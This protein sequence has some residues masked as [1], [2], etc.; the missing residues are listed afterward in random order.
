M[1]GRSET[2]NPREEIMRRIPT[3]ILA[4]VLGLAIG[5]C[6]NGGS[7]SGV[8]TAPGEDTVSTMDAVPGEDTHPGTDTIPGTDT[9]PAEDTSPPEDVPLVED[10]LVGEDT[11]PGA[12][13]VVG[14]DTQPGEDTLQPAVCADNNDCAA[15]E[16]CHKVYCDDAEGGC[17]VMPEGCEKNLA[18]VCGCD[19]QTYDNLCM[20]YAVGVNVDYEGECQTP[21]AQNMDCPLYWFCL[22]EECGDDTGL[23]E[24]VPQ[25]CPDVWD[26]VC[27]CNGVTYGNECD[28]WASGVSVDVAGECVF[29]NCW[30]NDM[31]PL[32]EFCLLPAC[33]SK[34]GDCEPQP[35]LCPQV[36]EPVCGCDDETYGNQCSA[37]AAG[38][39]VAYEGECQGGPGGCKDNGD[40]PNDQFCVKAIGDCLGQGACG[41][42]PGACTMQY[43]PACGCD[44]Q[45]Y[46]NS[47]L[48]ASAGVSLQSDGPCP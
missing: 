35:E 31:C 37:W 5:A 46:G 30:D 11:E 16:F 33:G 39:T 1:R 21:C 29:E 2:D 8:D 28:A 24:P 41:P 40:C 10:T 42:I 23:C 20:A 22:L 44:G 36:W 26:P 34:S 9:A 13:T 25:G 15:W 3:T 4:I 43:D 47:C 27:G 17:A 32:G 7:S 45:T 14:E 6:D 18:P 48:A 38:V 12:D 19:G